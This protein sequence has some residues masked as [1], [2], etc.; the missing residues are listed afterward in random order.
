MTFNLD[1]SV[2]AMTSQP[3]D[4]FSSFNG[5][6]DDVAGGDQG[7][8]VTSVV[9]QIVRDLVT[10][11]VDEVESVDAVA[12]G[13]TFCCHLSNCVRL[14]SHVISRLGRETNRVAIEMKA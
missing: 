9:R 8:D 2:E 10:S 11:A 7:D 3:D 5:Y 1:T 12:N 14:H 4:E 13:E 6:A